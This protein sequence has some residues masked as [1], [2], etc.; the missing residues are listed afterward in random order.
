M[1]VQAYCNSLR[2]RILELEKEHDMPITIESP[3]FAN[4]EPIPTKHTGEGPDVSPP[5]RWS[6]LPEGTRELALICDDPD[7]PRAEPW[8]HWVLYGL[9]APVAGLPEGLPK[10]ARLAQPAAHQGGTDFGRVGY[11]GPMPPKGHGR[12][13]YFFRLYAL[14]QALEL[15]PGL[16]KKKLLAALRP[17]VIG[18]GVLMGTYERK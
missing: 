12:H 7:A 8:V 5:L 1:G 16:D 17:H 2:W 13:R 4:G 9:S 18:E 15:A 14:G 11:G 10:D 3:A 6:G